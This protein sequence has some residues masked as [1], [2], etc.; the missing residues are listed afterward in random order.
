M[1]EKDGIKLV[2]G[3]RFSLR[4]EKGRRNNKFKINS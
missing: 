2:Y 4:I 1:E 3:V